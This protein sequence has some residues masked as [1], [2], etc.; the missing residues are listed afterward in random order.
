AAG[1]REA[2]APLAHVVD[3]ARVGGAHA[4]LLADQEAAG[5]ERAA[6]E[7][8]HADEVGPPAAATAPEAAAATAERHD[9]RAAGAAGRPGQAAEQVL[10]REV[11]LVDVVRHRDPG[12]PRRSAHDGGVAAALVALLVA[13]AAVD[14]AELHLQVLEDEVHRLLGLPVVEAAELRLVAGLVVH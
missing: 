1:D 5:I 9:A 7:A 11:A 10:D 3:A 13:V 8:A 2:R 6:A 12:Q 14:L 4:G